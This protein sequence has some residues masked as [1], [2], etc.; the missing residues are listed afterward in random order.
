MSVPEVKLYSNKAKFKATEYHLLLLRVILFFRFKN[1][2]GDANQDS[3]TSYPDS[4]R[5]TIR[6]SGG[7]PQGA[8]TVTVQGNGP[9]GTPVHG[10][11][12]KCK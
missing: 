1:K 12:I 9:N 6:S 5:F 2:T 10:R 4:L 7:I 8:Y 11:T 3:L